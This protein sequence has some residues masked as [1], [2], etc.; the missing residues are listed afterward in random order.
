MKNLF[1]KYRQFIIGV[2]ATVLIITLASNIP[3]AMN[4][5]SREGKDMQMDFAV[6]EDYGF[7]EN[8]VSSDSYSKSA[9]ES[10]FEFNDEQKMI[11]SSSMS[12]EVDETDLAV[13][14]IESLIKKYGSYI[15]SINSYITPEQSY[16][17]EDTKYFRRESKGYYM[18]IRVKA[19]NLDSFIQ[20][21]EQLGL[22]V[23]YSKS[24]Y[25]VTTQYTDLES[26]LELHQSKLKRLNELMSE[27]ASLSDLIT[28]ENA[29]STEIYQIDQIMTSLNGLDKEIAYSSL[30]INITE[31]EETTLTVTETNFFKEIGQAFIV[32]INGFV[33]NTVYF[34]GAVIYLIPYSII[35]GLLYLLYRKFKR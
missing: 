26:R 7:A 4:N 12:L 23:N 28:L 16:Y 11:Y 21:V 9:S 2:I 22:V 25:N 29:I 33:N 18:T 8:S 17:I 19:E 35:L 30:Y 1:M 27:T 15:E 31:K 20:E 6:S 10:E 14:S 32:S 34:L 24:A 3:K 13:D 5:L